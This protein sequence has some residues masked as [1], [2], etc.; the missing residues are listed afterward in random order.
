MNERVLE[1]IKIEIKA[2]LHRFGEHSF[3]DNGPDE[4]MDVEKWVLVLTGLPIL[5]CREILRELAEGTSHE[6][7][8]VESVLKYMQDD[9]DERF[10]SLM[11]ENVLRAAF[12]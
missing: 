12:G 1:R 6:A 9:S 7:H 10:D 3:I 5:Q 8:F 11:E 4:V 2:A